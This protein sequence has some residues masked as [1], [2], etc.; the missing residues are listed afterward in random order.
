MTP[1]TT[2]DVVEYGPPSYDEPTYHCRLCW[3]EPNGWIL[4]WCPGTGPH[5]VADAVTPPRFAGTERRFCGRQPKEGHGPHAFA[6]RCSC[7]DTN[8]V[9]QRARLQMR[10][11]QRRHQARQRARG[12]HD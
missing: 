6:E 5:R 10:E 12:S 3:D 8:P 7:V 11:A 4:C 9:I 2:D 1:E